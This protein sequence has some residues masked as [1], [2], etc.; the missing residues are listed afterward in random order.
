MIHYA[1][2]T[3]VCLTVGLR[4]R[5]YITQSWDIYNTFYHNRIDLITAEECKSENKVSAVKT[6]YTVVRSHSY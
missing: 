2:I 6:R 1:K 3:E 5:W 4:S